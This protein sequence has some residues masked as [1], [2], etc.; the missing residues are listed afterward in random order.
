M[1]VRRKGEGIDIPVRRECIAVRSHAVCSVLYPP[2]SHYIE[3]TAA[4]TEPTLALQGED[5]YSH[6]AL[7]HRAVLPQGIWPI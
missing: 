2:L 6:T 7:S 1:S 3:R 4:V 5:L